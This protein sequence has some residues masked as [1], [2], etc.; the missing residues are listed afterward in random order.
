MSDKIILRKIHLGSLIDLLEYL[1][2]SGAVFVDIVGLANAPTEQD[3]ILVAVNPEYFKNDDDDDNDDDDVEQIPPL[4]PF[5]G[6]SKKIKEEQ[7]K[8]S[9]INDV[10]NRLL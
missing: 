3:E 8:I 5:S 10:I 9:D 2:D 6:M 1:Y 7:E 4:T